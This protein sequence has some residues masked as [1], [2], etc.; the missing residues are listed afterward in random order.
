[1]KDPVLE[2]IIKAGV[3]HH[4]HRIFLF[5][6]RGRQDYKPT[7]DYDIAVDGGFDTN[8]KKARFVDDIEQIET[9]KKIDIIFMEDGIGSALESSIHRD[10]VVIYESKQ[11]ESR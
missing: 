10:G 4:A 9:L 1:M 8:L 7:S 6:S 2:Q 3:K 11:D 5:G